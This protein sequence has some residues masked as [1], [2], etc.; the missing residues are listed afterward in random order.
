M[1]ISKRYFKEPLILPSIVFLAAFA[2]TFGVR[3]LQPDIAYTSDGIS[4]L[5]MIN[6][7]S[8]G[9][10]LPPPDCWLPPYRFEWYYDL[11]HYAASVMERLLA[12]KVAVP[13][14]PIP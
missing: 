8:Q 1:S 5:N 7:F 10:T 9:Q 13:L 6:N 11:Q 4:D 12:V 14:L 3:C 2:F